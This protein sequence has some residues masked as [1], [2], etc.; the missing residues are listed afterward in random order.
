MSRATIRGLDSLLDKLE[1]LHSLEADTVFEEGLARGAAK[2]VAMAKR[3]VPVQSGDLR[4]NLH[5][6][7]YTKLTPGYRAVGA[8]GALKGPIGSGKS[9]GVLAGSKLPYAGRVER[10][11]KFARPHPYL[12][13]AV[14]QSQR[15]IADE[16]ETAIQKMIDRR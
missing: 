10:G 4:D 14:D 8:Y 1:E 11:T 9:V 16:C 13:P 3:L 2:A 15:E 5:V 6:G 12:R 7:G